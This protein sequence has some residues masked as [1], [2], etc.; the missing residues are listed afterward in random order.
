MEAEATGSGEDLPKRLTSKEASDLIRMISRVNQ[1]KRCRCSTL[2][3]TQIRCV[4]K[5]KAAISPT[6]S[7]RSCHDISA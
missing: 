7:L 1:V 4:E 5:N 6:P 2:S 3:S